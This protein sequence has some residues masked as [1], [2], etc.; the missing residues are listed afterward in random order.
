VTDL[1][2]LR[3]RQLLT[4]RELAARLGVRRQQ[5]IS[6]WERGVARPLPRH[7]RALCAA[8]RVTVDDLL[9]ALDAVRVAR[10]QGQPDA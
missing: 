10:R 8:L 4:Q 5:T 6:D 1:K 7:R 3:E 9:A 2:A